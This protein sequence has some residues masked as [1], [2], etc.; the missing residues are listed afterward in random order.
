MV[1]KFDRLSRSIR[2]FCEMYDRYFRHGQK[3]LIAIREAIRLDSALGRALIGI[4]LVFAQMEREAAGERVR[5]TIRHIRTNG[6]HFGKIPFGKRAVPAPDNPRMRIL[7]DD[8]GVQAVLAQ[9]RAWAAEGLGIS[10]MTRRL[11]AAGNKPPQ[12]DS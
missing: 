2:H 7:I 5:E 1:V 10:E 6:Y 12:G 11:N 8:E 4:L 9:L 3:E